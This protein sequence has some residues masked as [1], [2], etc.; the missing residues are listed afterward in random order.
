MLVFGADLDKEDKNLQRVEFEIPTL[1][2]KYIG[3][4]KPPTPEEIQ[5]RIRNGQTYFLLKDYV[6]S[7][8]LLF[9]IVEDPRNKTHPAYADAVYYLAE[10]LYRNGNIRGARS[11]YQELALSENPYRPDALLRLLE[12]AT[13]NQE[14]QRIDELL[15]DAKEIP[16]PSAALSHIIGKALFARRRYDE[17]FSAFAKVP[18]SDELGLPA[19]YYQGV[20][21]LAQAKALL[22]VARTPEAPLIVTEEANRILEDAKS[23]FQTA[24]N[25]TIRPE[26][27]ELLWLSHLA[28]GRIYHETGKEDDAA[29][30][31]L[32]IP[33]SSESFAASRY[34][35]AWVFIAQNDLKRAY[36]NLESMRLFVKEGPIISEV[37]ILEGSILSSLK[38][39]PEA[40]ATYEDLRQ[41]FSPIEDQINA[42]LLKMPEESFKTQLEKE[43][44]IDARDLLP[45]LARDWMEPSD[46]VK[47]SLELQ[48]DLRLIDANIKECDEIAALLESKLGGKSNIESFSILNEGRQK[49]LSLLDAVYS[50]RN[51]AVSSM[52]TEL[53][54][55]ASP[56]EKAKLNE[57]GREQQRVE[58]L[59]KTIPKSR[60][61][62]KDREELIS[63]RFS[64]LLRRQHQMA[65]KVDGLSARLVALKK[66]Y[67]DTKTSE[68]ISAAQDAEFTNKLERL[69][70]INKTLNT[71]LDTL[72]AEIE[73]ERA[74]VGTNDEAFE[75]ED[76]IR[77]YYAYVLDQQVAVLNEIAS[78]QAPS[79]NVKKAQG[80]LARISKDESDI[81]SFFAALNATLKFNVEQKLTEVQIEKRNLLKYK[82]ELSLLQIE[83]WNISGKV[84]YANLLKAQQDF[85]DLVLRSNVGIIDVSWEMKEKAGKDL[86]VIKEKKQSDLDALQELFDEALKEQ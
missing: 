61:D 44:V 76:D 42:T 79:N 38:R 40:L 28:L 49:G 14:E 1:Q 21:R 84:L 10:S 23:I 15:V 31:Y 74:N 80:L 12:A 4:T 17:A 24:L 18:A 86:E 11:F 36:T 25:T 51:E 47:R 22:D 69:N 29:K 60:D 66:Y 71:D 81:E 7:S 33:T 55:F 67:N 46:L 2:S 58:D 20:T 13:N 32:S 59:F 8:I 9:D 65:L 63:D 70:A 48:E 57:M 41:T 78:R 85:R 53:L 73:R 77:N 50:V 52:A 26:Q 37:L 75:Q 35:V 30:E 16:Q 27:A 68:G 6:R 64:E 19:L 3:S 43:G 54:P 34:E 62:Y 56:N 83:G 39:Y 5:K 45:P 82:E 72:R